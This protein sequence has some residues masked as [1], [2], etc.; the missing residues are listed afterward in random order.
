VSPLR[1]RL[2][3]VANDGE[4]GEGDNVERDV[5]EARGGVNRDDLIGDFRTNALEGGEGEDYVDGGVGKD[6]LRGGTD[7]DYIR[8]RDG[9]ADV[10]LCGPDRDFAVVDPIDR[11]L[12]C[13]RVDLGR[14]RPVVGDSAVGSPAGTVRLKLAGTRRFVPLVDRINIPFGSTIDTRAGSVRVTAAGAVRRISR[15]KKRRR[16]Q[17]AVLSHGIFTIA[18]KR[19][20]RPV[21]ELRLAGGRFKD[22]EGATAGSVRTSRKPRKKIR[23]LWGEGH[24]RIKTVGRYSATTVRG[25][26]WRVEDRCEGTYTQIR[27]GEAVVFDAVRHRRV[28]V[29]AGHHYLAAAP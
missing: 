27:R 19:A 23:E 13:E 26:S 18:Q 11:V 7:R 25:T 8:A 9:V 14:G 21:T 12:G 4:A 10:V 1:V 2:D 17:R 3:G 15:F 20:S 29:R 16:K 5:E 22:C 24:G 6:N 28:I